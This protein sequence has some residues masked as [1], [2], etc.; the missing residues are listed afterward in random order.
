MNTNLH[1]LNQA[2]LSVWNLISLFFDPCHNYL[3]ASRCL[4]LRMHVGA[5]EYSSCN[6]SAD[7]S[8]NLRVCGGLADYQPPRHHLSFLNARMHARTHTIH[9]PIR[10]SQ[11]PLTPS[12]PPPHFPST[13]QPRMLTSLRY[14]SLVCASSLLIFRAILFM[15]LCQCSLWLLLTRNSKQFE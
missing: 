9:H 7:P 3:S 15:L 12:H 10:A 13:Q 11:L 4:P 6:K 14:L 8:I 5:R 1:V 2:L